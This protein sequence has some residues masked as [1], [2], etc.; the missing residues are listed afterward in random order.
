MTSDAAKSKKRFL[1]RSA[2]YSGLLNVL[3]FEEADALSSNT[4]KNLLVG[5]NAFI[6][7]DMPRESVASISDAALAAGVKRLIVTT[8]LEKMDIN[9]TMIPEFDEAQTAFVAAGGA[10]TGI[11]HGEIVEGNEDNNYEIVNATVPCLDNYIERGI[12]A[13]VVAE[14]L[15]ISTSANSQ[16]GIS[17]S[18]SFSA[19]YLNVLRSSGLS[20]NEEVAKMFSGG[21][22]R[23]ARLTVNE[24]ES[25]AR[26]EEERTAEK[27]RQR[28][29]EEALELAA[30]SRNEEG[31]KVRALDS[32]TGSRKELDDEASITPGWDED[33]EG[34]PL[35]DE[36]KMLFKTEAILKTVW[37]E[38][39]TRMV[40]KQTSRVEFYDLNRKKAEELAKIELEEERSV[41]EDAEF[42]SRTDKM[43][44]DRFEDRNRKQYAKLIALERNEM[45]NQ[46]EISDTWVKYIYLLLEITMAHCRN[47]NILFHNEDTFSQTLL[48]RKKANELRGLCGLPSYEVVYD[49]LDACAIVNFL[50]NE[51]SIKPQSLV[52]GVPIDL[53]LDDV[54]QILAL[55]NAKHGK[56]LRIIPALRGASQII[57]MAIDTLKQELPQPPPPVNEIRRTESSAKKEAVSEMRLQAI[58]N[59]GKPIDDE[60]P[61][62]KL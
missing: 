58:Q 33:Q 42:D 41:A 56:V 8:S 36:Q 39:D 19:A 49:P 16:C 55:L 27:E 28:S 59:R 6:A 13:R 52:L 26:R 15:S 24:Y 18:G 12:L 51:K 31:K 3:E 45:Q 35:T 1:T 54:D 7:L 5:A 50:T 40:T 37:A 38:Y 47:E 25:A 20:R 34:S 61:V 48:L 57:E 53:S 4:M 44:L 23:V 43:I 62:G 46:K 9:I 2:R 30:K 60:N 22:Q 21:L 29:E 32:G 11:R 17:S 14:L 10:F